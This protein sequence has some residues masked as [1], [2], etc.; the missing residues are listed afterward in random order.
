[1]DVNGHGVNHHKGGMVPKVLVEE[2]EQELLVKEETIQ[3]RGYY[4]IM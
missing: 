3:V 1:M 4:K 2:K